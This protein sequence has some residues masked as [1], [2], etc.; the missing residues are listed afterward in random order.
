M[1]V[2]SRRT[3][4]RILIGK[5]IEILV[6]DVDR[7]NVRIGIRCPRDIPVFRSELCEDGVMPRSLAART[8]T[9][10]PTPKVE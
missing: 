6:C 1:L 3:G 2:L 10:T 9:P 7:G 5:D 4:E 8:P